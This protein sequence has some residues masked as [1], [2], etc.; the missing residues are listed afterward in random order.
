MVARSFEDSS[1]IV[2]LCQADLAIPASTSASERLFSI[3]GLFDSLK[4]SRLD[5]ETLELLTLLKTN[6]TVFEF[7]NDDTDSEEETTCDENDDEND[8][9]KSFEEGSDGSRS[10]ERG[11]DLESS[12]EDGDTD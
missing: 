9:D 6:N 3:G 5:P 2:N 1:Q 7:E 11:G 12:E 10:S 4:R 8:A